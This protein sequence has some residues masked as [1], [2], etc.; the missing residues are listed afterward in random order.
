MPPV[1]TSC[2]VTH[3]APST[4][5]GVLSSDTNSSVAVKTLPAC[6]EYVRCSVTVS[7]ELE[8]GAYTYVNASSLG[9]VMRPNDP[10]ASAAV[11]MDRAPSVLSAQLVAKS[12]PSSMQ[13]KAVAVGHR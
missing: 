11:R 1:D 12:E 6:A 8:N 3:T 9:A 2:S 4:N 7:R 5:A 10:G 13:R